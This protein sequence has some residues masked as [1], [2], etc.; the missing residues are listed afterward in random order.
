MFQRK[1]GLE[2][3]LQWETKK[4]KYTDNIYLSAERKQGGRP[5]KRQMENETKQSNMSVGI[6]KIVEPGNPNIQRLYVSDKVDEAL[7]EKKKN[8]M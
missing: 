8:N 1:N 3:N 6:V 7:E 5:E 2:Q 4:K